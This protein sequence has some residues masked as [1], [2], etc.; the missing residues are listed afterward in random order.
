M[1]TDDLSGTLTM[2]TRQVDGQIAKQQMQQAADGDSSDGSKRK[3]PSTCCCCCCRWWRVGGGVNSVVVQNGAC[4]TAAVMTMLPGKC[5]SCASQWI[6]V[7]CWRLVA[8]QPVGRQPAAMLRALAGIV[9][10]VG[11]LACLL[12]A[13]D[14]SG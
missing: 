4:I 8:G 7:R 11:W 12:A 14:L 2:M 1:T 13:A 9:I 5:G 3:C 6:V 10:V